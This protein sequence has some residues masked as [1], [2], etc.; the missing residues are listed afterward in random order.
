MGYSQ[1]EFFSYLWLELELILNESRG[2]GVA[3][4]QNLGRR[5]P[6]SRAQELRLPEHQDGR[7]PVGSSPPNSLGSAEATKAQ[8]RQG[9]CPTSHS[10]LV[11]GTRTRTRN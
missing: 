9:T 3:L 4:I 1:T 10:E 11:G 7:H 5:C 6:I 8:R 2:V